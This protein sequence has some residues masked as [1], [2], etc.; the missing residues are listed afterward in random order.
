MGRMI[1][2]GNLDR[3][4]HINQRRLD[5]SETAYLGFTGKSASLTF[6]GS[7]IVID[8]LDGLESILWRAVVSF[9]VKRA[10]I[11]MLDVEIYTVSGDRISF[12]IPS[13]GKDEVH[14]SNQIL[15]H[16]VKAGH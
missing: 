4:G 9:T 3:G 15:K 13:D 16:I 14:M 12:G 1:G 5:P 6:T 10:D 11:G 7:R 2:L 8:G